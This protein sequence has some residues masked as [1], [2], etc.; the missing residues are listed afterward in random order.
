MVSVELADLRMAVDRKGEVFRQLV[1]DI[2]DAA[3][4]PSSATVGRERLFCAR[5]CA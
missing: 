4:S 1:T 5:S 3:L 2:S